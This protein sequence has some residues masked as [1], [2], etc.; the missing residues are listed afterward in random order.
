MC[1]GDMG[2]L[3]CRA[4]LRARS[5][6][7]VKQTIGYLLEQLHLIPEDTKRLHL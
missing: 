4:R 3:F 7:A 1:G 5:R 2:A 6:F